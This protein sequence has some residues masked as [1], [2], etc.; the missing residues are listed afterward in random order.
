V[1]K[2]VVGNPWVLNGKFKDLTPTVSNMSGNVV[3]I[4]VKAVYL[5]TC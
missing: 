5:K 2:T 4:I 1:F 3:V